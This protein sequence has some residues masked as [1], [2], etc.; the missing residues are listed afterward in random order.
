MWLIKLLMETISS[1]RNKDRNLKGVCL[2]V[3]VQLLI[4]YHFTQPQSAQMP[5]QALNSHVGRWCDPIC[6]TEDS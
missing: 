4:H 1:R 3:C 6:M 2:C 5:A